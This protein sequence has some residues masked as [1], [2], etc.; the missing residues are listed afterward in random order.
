MTTTGLG[1]LTW[2]SAATLALTLKSHEIS[3]LADAV[4]EKVVFIQ[5]MDVESVAIAKAFGYRAEGCLKNIGIQDGLKSVAE[6]LESDRIILNENDFQTISTP[7]ETHSELTTAHRLMDE[8]TATYVM[9]RSLHKPGAPD[10]IAENYAD[11]F[12]GPNASPRMKR[13][14]ARAL[15][16][17]AP[18]ARYIAFQMS[19]IRGDFEDTHPGIVERLDGDW[20]RIPAK[21]QLWSNNPMLIDRRFF[22][23]KLIAH[24]EEVT[25]RAL[26]NGFPNLENEL[27]DRWWRAQDWWVARGA[28]IFQHRRLGDRGY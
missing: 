20:L 24:A 11:F 25:P 17:R 16:R 22:L 13:R 21:W 7:E 9:L 3:G 8:G 26:I 4:D 12:P 18:K 19:I 23:D 5:E 10:R 6:C 28:G 14:A 2:R 1:I 27:N 15:E